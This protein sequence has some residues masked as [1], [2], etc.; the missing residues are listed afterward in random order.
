LGSWLSEGTTRRKKKKV[1]GR[2]LDEWGGPRT[3]WSCKV[4]R[5]GGKAEQSEPGKK[6]RVNLAGLREEE[7]SK[8]GNER[9][10]ERTLLP[11][12]SRGWRIGKRVGPSH[13]RRREKEQKG[14]AVKEADT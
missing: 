5:T 2:D 10:S 9:N 12:K 6:E 1:G 14:S 4:R 11:T 7:Q 3:Y 13:I 8:K